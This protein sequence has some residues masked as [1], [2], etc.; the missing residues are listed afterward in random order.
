MKEKKAADLLEKIKPVMIEALSNS[1]ENL[2]I[3][4]IV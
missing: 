1:T 3:T 4:A 2:C